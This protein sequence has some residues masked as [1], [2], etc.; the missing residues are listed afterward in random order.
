MDALGRVPVI[1]LQPNDTGP[2]IRLSLSPYREPHR[3][4]HVGAHRDGGSV[5]GEVPRA[6]TGGVQQEL[7]E[8]VGQNLGDVLH[9][10]PIL[11]GVAE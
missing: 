11:I 3:L 5:A 2:D 1:L 9:R 10:N 6:A 4:L 8:G 7:A